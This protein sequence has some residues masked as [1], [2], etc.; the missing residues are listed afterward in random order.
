MSILSAAKAL[1]EADATLLAAATGGI[2]D[3]DESGRLGINRTA[4]P[5]AFTS[6][7]IIKPCV[8]VKT[9][10]PVADYIL[11][12]DAS[13]LVSYREALEIWLYQDSG[14]TTIETM[15]SRIFALLHA[16]Q[17]GG[18]FMCY[19]QQNVRFPIR[20]TD[21][22]ANVERMEFSVRAKRSV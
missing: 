12:D 6:A 1:L 21:L 5:S 2:W 13:Q 3:W 20:D 14:F 19:W 15:E 9:R 22:D 18:A 7:G 10:A 11:A 8:L 17:F 4:N 16:K